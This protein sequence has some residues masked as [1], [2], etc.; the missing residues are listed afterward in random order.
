MG[1]GQGKV[2]EVLTLFDLLEGEDSEREEF[3]GL[4][5]D[6]ALKGLEELQKQKKVLVFASENSEAVGDCAGFEVFCCGF[7]VF[8]F[9]LL[10]QP[11]L[12]GLQVEELQRMMHYQKKNL[13]EETVVDVVV[14]QC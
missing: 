1:H 2:G 9:F 10:Q 11:G 3:F 8:F 4:P 6:L 13:F 5:S 14:A 12:Q 7:F